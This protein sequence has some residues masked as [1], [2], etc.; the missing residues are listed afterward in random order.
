MSVL[1]FFS[2]KGK[3]KAK[4]NSQDGSEGP[5]VFKLKENSEKANG[6]TTEEEQALAELEEIYNREKSKDEE[7]AFQQSLR[8]RKL[9]TTNTG[10]MRSI[11]RRRSSVKNVFTEPEYNANGLQ[12]FRGD[13][14]AQEV[15]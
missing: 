6:L 1:K 5:G 7:H 3:N 9:S 2:R 10:R 14:A 8:S 13:T 12:V 15:F 11:Q 4:K